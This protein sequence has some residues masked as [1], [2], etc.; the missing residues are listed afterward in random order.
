M[1]SLQLSALFQ[2]PF[3]GD[4]NP[5]VVVR[6]KLV[7]PFTNNA[8]ITYPVMEDEFSVN[9]GGV[10]V[11]G[12]SNPY[13]TLAVADAGSFAKYEIRINNNPPIEALLTDS[14]TGTI[15]LNEILVGSLSLA[16][17]DVRNVTGTVHKAILDQAWAKG[18]IVVTLTALW[19]ST[20]AV[21][22]P[23]TKSVSLD[24]SGTLDTGFPFIVPIAGDYKAPY[25]IATPD[26]AE[27]LCYLDNAPASIALDDV[28]N[29]VYATP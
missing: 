27:Y 19:A 13:V 29:G 1:P 4:P 15:T 10:L 20:A 16:N 17:P 26:G 28:V 9:S 7:E 21:Y 14:I 22:T 5:D 8:G 2:N 18:Q 12:A 23:A 25:T 11:D 3:N 24:A 6:I